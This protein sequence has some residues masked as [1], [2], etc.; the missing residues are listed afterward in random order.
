MPEN[1]GR[2][3]GIRFPHLPDEIKPDHHPGYELLTESQKIVADGLSVAEKRSILAIEMG[4]AAISISVFVGKI[5]GAAIIAVMLVLVL[6]EGPR[7]VEMLRAH[8]GVTEAIK[9]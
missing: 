4:E 6:L 8:Y 1:G 7:L 3:L 5:L 9:R 2:F